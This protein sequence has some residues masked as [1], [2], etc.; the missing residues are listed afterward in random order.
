[1]SG[2][3]TREALVAEVRRLVFA[4]AARRRQAALAALVAQRREA[5]LQR[6]AVLAAGRLPGVRDAVHV[7]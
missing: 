4:R 6:M 7:V 5:Y 1:M 3:L 2:C